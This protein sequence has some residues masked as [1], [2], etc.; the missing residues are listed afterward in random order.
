MPGMFHE[1]IVYGG[2]RLDESVTQGQTYVLFDCGIVAENVETSIGDEGTKV[3][4][5]L[6]EYGV[7][8]GAVGAPFKA[9]TFASAIVAKVKRK[10]PGDLPAVV[11]FETV[12]SKQWGNDAF[13]MSFVQRYTGD[14]PETLPVITAVGEVPFD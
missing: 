13:V 5:V 2:K 6:A 7:E 14:T 8:S 12:Q 1:D 11:Q 4:L 9:G 10:Q 3:E